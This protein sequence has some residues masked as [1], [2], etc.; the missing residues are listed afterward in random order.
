[1]S[2]LDNTNLA[3]FKAKN[4]IRHEKTCPLTPEQ[5]GVAERISRTVIE[6]IRCMLGKVCC[7]SLKTIFVGYADGAKG[8]PVYGPVK[9]DIRI[10][11]DVVVV[12]E[13]QPPAIFGRS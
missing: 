6:K 11:R 13:G 2:G 5:D 7:S 12:Q 1:M 10:S 3:L 4:G 8:Y 9:R